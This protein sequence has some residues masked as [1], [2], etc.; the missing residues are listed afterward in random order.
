MEPNFNDA[1]LDQITRA[2]AAVAPNLDDNEQP[3][4]ESAFG[5]ACALTAIMQTDAA[6]PTAD[7]GEDG[8][9]VRRLRAPAYWM[10]GSSDGHEGEND[11][12]REAADRLIL[13]RE[14]LEAIAAN[15]TAPEFEPSDAERAAYWR[16]AALYCRKVARAVLSRS[17]G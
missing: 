3:R 11:A 7:L 10:S 13:Y 14:A 1:T 8:E 2:N 9:L 15:G 17:G 5:Y 16:D 12:P 4:Y 6:R